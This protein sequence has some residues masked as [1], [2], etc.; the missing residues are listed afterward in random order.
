MLRMDGQANLTGIWR[1]RYPQGSMSLGLA[2]SVQDV[3]RFLREAGLL[4]PKWTAGH[5]RLISDVFSAKWPAWA[6]VSHPLAKRA[7]DVEPARGQT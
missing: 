6:A 3:T 4:D 7:G 2:Y 1:L 5:P